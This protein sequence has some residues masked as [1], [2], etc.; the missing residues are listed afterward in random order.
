[1]TDNSEPDDR[2][3]PGREPWTEIRDK[4]Q[5][6]RMPAVAAL[7][8]G[9]DVYMYSGLWWCEGKV[10]KVT[11]EGADV[12]T[13]VRSDREIVHF[14]AKGVSYLTEHEWLVEGGQI[15]ING[16]LEC[17]PW[18]IDTDMSFAERK[19]WYKDLTSKI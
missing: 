16:T 4:N 2:S 6:K 8:V 10:A 13:P 18:I 5:Q 12:Q 1:V 15:K 17:G 3:S 7:V 19:A 9:Q 14:D 11:P